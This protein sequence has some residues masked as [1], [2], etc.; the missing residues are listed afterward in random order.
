MFSLFLLFSNSTGK[1]CPFVQS[2]MCIIYMLFHNCKHSRVRNLSRRNTRSI[3]KGW[4]AFWIQLSV[5]GCAWVKGKPNW[6]KK[7]P[8]EEQLYNIFKV[9]LRSIYSIASCYWFGGW[10]FFCC[11]YHQHQKFKSILLT[12]EVGWFFCVQLSWHWHLPNHS[13]AT[14]AYIYH[15]T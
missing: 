15:Y 2:F 11:V 4:W 9:I 6:K 5:Q 14:I 1:W 10:F 7:I 8:S 12:A 3:I 13:P